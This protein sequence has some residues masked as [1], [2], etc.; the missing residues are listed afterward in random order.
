MT[1]LLDPE[2]TGRQPDHPDW[3]GS[4][5]GSLRSVLSPSADE[6]EADELIVRRNGRV[7]VVDRR[8]EC[9][10]LRGLLRPRDHRP[11]ASSTGSSAWASRP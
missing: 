2:T 11:A 1:D 7:S 4:L 10:A 8:R 9:G 3:A 5:R 6:P